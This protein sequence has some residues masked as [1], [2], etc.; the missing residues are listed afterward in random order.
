MFQ[1][2][3]R[4]RVS[5]GPHSVIKHD[6]I[7]DQL[8]RDVDKKAEG[9]GKGE[10]VGRRSEVGREEGQKVTVKPVLTKERLSCFVNNT[11]KEK[12]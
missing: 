2:R 4:G 11:Q 8:S 9:E 10:A 5:K 7:M 12:I 3:T 1:T 6:K